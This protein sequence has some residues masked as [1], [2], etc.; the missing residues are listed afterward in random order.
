MKIDVAVGFSILF[1]FSYAFSLRF[2]V[3]GKTPQEVIEYSAVFWERCNELTDMD[4]IMAQI[5][6]GEAR[7]QRKISVKK[8]L[9]AKV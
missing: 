6:R 2:K 1:P 3:E 9:D 4:K 8:A 5:E 7:I